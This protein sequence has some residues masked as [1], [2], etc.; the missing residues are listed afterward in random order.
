MFLCQSIE[1]TVTFTINQIYFTQKVFCNCCHSQRNDIQIQKKKEEKSANRNNTSTSLISDQ[2]VR[3]SYI[4]LLT[5]NWNLWFSGFVFE[6]ICKR[7]VP[8][9]YSIYEWEIKKNCFK[10]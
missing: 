9:K 5:I 8:L 4:Q 7:I 2:H 10:S 3:R 1:Y 6:F